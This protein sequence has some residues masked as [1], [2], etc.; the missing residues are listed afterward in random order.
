MFSKVLVGD[1]VKV[2]CNEV[3]HESGEKHSWQPSHTVAKRWGQVE[4]TP[5]GP[6]GKGV[7]RY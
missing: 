3:S 1:I 2:R 5:V 4:I 7:C 6:L